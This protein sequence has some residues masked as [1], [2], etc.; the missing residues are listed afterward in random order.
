MSMWMQGVTQDLRFGVRRHL[1]EFWF[2]AAAALALALGIASTSTVFTIVN[3][4][5]LKGAPVSDSDRLIALSMR[6]ARNRQLAMAQPDF[7]DWR[8]ASKSFSGMTLMVQVA[9]SVSDE[10][11]TPEQYF[12]PFTSTNLFSLIGQRPILGRDFTP[13]DDRPNAPPVVI[14]SHGLWMSRYGG[15]SA[16]IGRTIRLNG[17]RPIII[18]V[19]APGMK[20]PPNSDLWMPLGQTNIGRVEGRRVRS[21][22]LIGRLADGVTLGQARDEISAIAA[23]LAREYPETNRDLVPDL[24][25]YSERVNGPQIKS[26]YLALMGAAAF[27]LLIACSNVANLLL[28]RAA[29][30]RRE[31]GVRLSLGAT[32]WRI[33]RQLL[34]ESGI[35]ALF[36]GVLA[37]PLTV[38]TIR[39]F[40]AATLDAARPY[41]VEYSLDGAVFAFFTAICLASG[42]FFGLAPALH[43]SKAD[44]HDK[45]KEGGRSAS[46]GHGARRWTNVLGV[47]QLALTVML[48]TG[49]GLLIHSFSNMYAMSAGM[50]TSRVITM[51]FALPGAKYP[52]PDDRLAFLKRVDD[53]LVNL[54]SLDAVATTSHVPLGGGLGAQI[55]F[56]GR[57][58]S[59]DERPPI[60]TLVSVGPRYF[61]ALNLR[62]LAGRSLTEDDGLIGHEGVVVNERF[63]AMYFP[64]QDPLGHRI[65]LWQDVSLRT[66]T[67]PSSGWSTIVGISPTVRQ[68]NARELDADP[69]VYVPRQLTSQGNRATLLVRS[70]LDPATTTALLRD[71]IRLL[72]PDMPL[73]NIHTMA[74]GLAQQRWSLAIAGTTFGSFAAIALVLSGIGLYALTAYGVSQRRQE[75]GVRVALGAR[76]SQIIWMILHRVLAQAVVGV[77]IGLV[78]AFA[79]ERTLQGLLVQTDATD[80]ITLTAAL[81]LLIVVVL[82]ACVWPA[83]RA[84]RLS[85]LTSLR[86]D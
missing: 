5:L 35:L 47:A 30:R 19:M 79:V 12:G 72:D 53:R 45:L 51:Q 7:E 80:P 15:D 74:E 44:L 38:G 69:V 1:K 73:F 18:G 62:V 21:F 67:A 33:V 56:D 68:R 61:E 66:P 22:Q 86:Y 75:I 36:S 43:S 65:R 24:S 34:V 78:G 82:N 77:A 31:I 4:V 49:T 46:A 16:V 85:P 42:L 23:R 13:E 10:A 3:A 29:Y 27:V 25:T 70:Q 58:P 71:E 28:A 59:P 50:D 8:A 37:I 64:G 54:H 20:F 40:D 41:Y 60:V 81:V 9:F 17:L 14:L 57:L 32:R 2:T 63:A 6:D 52:T 26:M 83:F 84:A 76:P 39:F 55:A 11:H 48:L